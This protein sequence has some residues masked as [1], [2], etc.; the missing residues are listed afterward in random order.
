MSYTRHRAIFYKGFPKARL[1]FLGDALAGFQV[2]FFFGED[3]ATVFLDIHALLTGEGLALAEIGAEVT[4]E[5][6]DTEFCGGSLSDLLHELVVLIG[7]DEQGGAE[8]VK[9]PL[10]GGLCRGEE[11]HFIALHT[12]I[13][14]ILRNLTDK[15]TQGILIP[16]QQ[17]QIN[18][19][20]IF[21]KTIPSGTVLRKG[22]NIG[23]IPKACQRYTVCPQDLD[24]LIGTGSTANM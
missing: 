3:T 7:A 15:G 20:G 18:A 9:A 4:V 11:P 14:Q 8:A 24:A 6:F 12:A 17:L 21:P 19:C 10:G 13:S 2:A 23:I 22:M 1:Y 16:F 5:E